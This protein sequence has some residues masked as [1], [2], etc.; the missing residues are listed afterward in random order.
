MDKPWREGIQDIGGDCTRSFAASPV[1]THGATITVDARPKGCGYRFAVQREAGTVAHYTL[2]VEKGTLDAGEMQISVIAYDGQRKL[3]RD[4]RRFQAPADLSGLRL[5]LD[6]PASARLIEL[7]FGGHQGARFSIEGV[8]LVPHASSAY[9]GVSGIALYEEAMQ[10]IAD[11]AYYARELPADFRE[12]WRP[13]ANA[14]PGEARSA[15]KR[16][17]KA[18]GDG[19][20]FLMDPARQANEPRI[21]RASFV[22]PQSEVLEPGIGYLVIPGTRAGNDALRVRYR[23]AVLDA[24]RAGSAQGVRGWVVDLR[25]NG[26]G[27]MWPM[28]AGL[29]PLLRGQTPGYFQRPDGSRDAWPNNTTAASAGAP[30]LGKV[31]VAVLTSGRT[32]SSGEAMVVAF[33]GRPNTRSFGAPTFG[34]ATANAGHR[35][36]DGTML[37]LTGALF[38]DR[39]GSGDGKPLVPDETVRELGVGDRTRQ[40]AIEWLRQQR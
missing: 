5:P 38:V 29:E 15:I 12:H 10:V 19:H 2:E 17:L 16:V 30:D 11:N 37:Q 8:R 22:A 21:A 36:A 23:D 9:M 25:D 31:P 28:L 33:R 13:A 32:G 39:N 24:L 40:S 20:S 18:L 7:S 6:V 3:D 4:Q 26:G 14:T 1:T 27:T 34:V 35:L